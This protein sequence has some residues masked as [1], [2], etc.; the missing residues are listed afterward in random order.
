MS[1]GG[2]FDPRRQGENF[3]GEGIVI[4]DE[5]PVADAVEL[6]NVARPAFLDKQKRREEKGACLDQSTART[7]HRMHN[8]S[9]PEILY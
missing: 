1:R 4:G 7:D 6:E 9:T 8:V 5:N 3:R 2:Q